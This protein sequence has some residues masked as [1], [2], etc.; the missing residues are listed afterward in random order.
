MFREERSARFL[1]PLVAQRDNVE[2]ERDC[3]AGV[4]SERSTGIDFPSFAVAAG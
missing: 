2:M 3:G 4:G 1:L